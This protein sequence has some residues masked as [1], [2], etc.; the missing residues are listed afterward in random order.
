[1]VMSSDF[2]SEREPPPHQQTRNCLKIKKEEVV[3][4]P[5]GVPD[6]KTD[7]PTDRRS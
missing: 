3:A 5:G 7:W 6:T 2:S 1:M 4:S